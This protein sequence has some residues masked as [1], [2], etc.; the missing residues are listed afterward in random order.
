MT[1]VNSSSISVLKRVRWRGKGNQ[2]RGPLLDR[3]DKEDDI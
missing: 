1:P 3:V 2:R